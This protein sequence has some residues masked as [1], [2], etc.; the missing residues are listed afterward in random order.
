MRNTLNYLSIVVFIFLATSLNDQAIAQTAEFNIDSRIDECNTYCA[1]VQIRSASQDFNLGG[2]SYVFAYNENA[3]NFLNSMSLNFDENSST[4]NGTQSAF[5]PQTPVIVNSKVSSGV[6]PAIFTSFESCPEIKNEWVDV[7]EYCFTITDST[8]FSELEWSDN[9]SQFAVTTSQDLLS[10]VESGE[11]F[12]PDDQLTCTTISSSIEDARNPSIQVFP[13][14]SNG[15]VQINAQA[16]Q[17]F[18]YSVIGQDGRVIKSGKA[19]S[20]E[21]IDISALNNGV[22]YI[23]VQQANGAAFTEKLVLVD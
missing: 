20:N 1:T 9:V 19:L 21:K 2:L 10:L 18:T 23:E 14:P 12:S 8:Q 4:C 7:A 16:D 22:Y 13:N 6:A 15:S 3:L 11:K 17:A 5:N